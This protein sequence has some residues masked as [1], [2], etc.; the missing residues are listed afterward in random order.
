MTNHERNN[1]KISEPLI[2]KYDKVKGKTI[3]DK[4]SLTQSLNKFF[5]NIGP[6]LAKKIPAAKTYF[7]EFLVLFHK[8]MEFKELFCQEFEMAFRTIKWE[9]ASGIYDLNAS[10]ILDVYEQI[11]NHCLLFSDHL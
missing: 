5:T 11:N 6:S 3:T 2:T 7:Q 10:V 9:K 8:E 1:W 4:N